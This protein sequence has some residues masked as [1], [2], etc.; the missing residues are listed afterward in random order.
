[1]DD[2]NQATLIKSMIGNWG[3]CSANLVCPFCNT[4]AIK[5]DRSAHTIK[6][7]EPKG[8]VALGFE[9]T[10]GHQW[11]L[12]FNLI[13]TNYYEDGYGVVE[14]VLAMGQIDYKAYIASDEWKEKAS[15]AKER[16]G[17]R[18][19]LCNAHKNK[20]SLHAH[21]RTYERLTNEE[22]G[23]ITVLCASCHAKFH[24]K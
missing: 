2:L 1:M 10:Q 21:H 5:W 12:A 6:R 3:A 15:A 14:L 18:C 8:A 4:E 9:C 17:Y 11:V 24:G 16:A 20:T 22:P 7:S 23:D 13:D 19:Q